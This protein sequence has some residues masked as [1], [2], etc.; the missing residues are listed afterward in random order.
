MPGTPILVNGTITTSGGSLADTG[1][2]IFT[3][4]GNKTAITTDVGK[5]V[6]DIS[7]IATK[8]DIITWVAYDEFENEI[9]TGSFTAADVQTVNA[10]TTPRTDQIMGASN[11]TA[12]IVNIGG[13]PI[14]FD[15]PFPI[16]FSDMLISHPHVLGNV[17][18]EFTITR[19]DNRP[20]NETVTFQDSTAYKRTFTYNSNGALTLRTRWIKQ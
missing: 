13:K 15:N 3:S 11:R 20:D 10:T 2:I 12:H 18:T 17:Q 5:Y 7:D 8:G 19:G 14:S 9:K 4:T 1:K 6:T 16:I